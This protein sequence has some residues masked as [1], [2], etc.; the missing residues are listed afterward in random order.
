ME[1]LSAD[2][3]LWGHSTVLAISTVLPNLLYQ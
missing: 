1:E 3:S 2:F